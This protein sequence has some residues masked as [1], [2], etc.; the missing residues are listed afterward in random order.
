MSVLP[1][2]LGAVTAA[3]A[4]ALERADLVV[5]TGGLGPT[6]DDLTREAI[7]ACVGETP[8]V[9]PG[10]ERWLRAL[11]RRRRI[12]FP[13]SNLKQA[14]LIPSATAI[15]NGNGTAP[16]WWIG[17][18]DGRIVVA[19]PG[20]PREMGPMWR[21]QVL[22]R[23]AERGL[24]V[25]R[26]VR[27]LKLTGIGESLLADRLADLLR[28]GN[29]IVATY[30][31]PDGVDIRVSAVDGPDGAADALVATAVAELGR[32]IGSHVWGYDADTWPS[33][34]DDRLT[35]GGWRLAIVEVG[36]GGAV[37]ALLGGIGAMRRMISLGADDPEA[38]PLGRVRDASG[39]LAG[40]AARTRESTAADVVLAVGA[41]DAPAGGDTIVGVAVAGPGDRLAH[42][43]RT[44]FLR[45][46]VARGRV[47]AAAAQV[48]LD[49]LRA[50]PDG[51]AA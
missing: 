9:D 25:P 20:P 26:A 27:T 51:D 17:R 12:E 6:P 31:R 33:V 4:L 47:A 3:F 18:P 36:T 38:S 29:P 49:A 19:L 45:G 16:G 11:W 8:T 14:W 40:L 42:E 22:P 21:Y 41:S 7:G 30:A 34:I 39:G 23:L 37:G 50:V 10:L 35:A 1:D 46:E 43:R 24:G 48:L 13:E 44:V 2:D 32:R 5:S 15:S 28:A